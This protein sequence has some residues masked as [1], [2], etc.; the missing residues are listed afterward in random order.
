MRNI[1]KQIKISYATFSAASKDGRFKP[2]NK[3]EAHYLYQSTHPPQVHS[4]E[5]KKKISEARKK[6]LKENPDKVPYLLNH[7]SHGISYP[8][9]YFKDCLKDTK[10]QHKYRYSTY[11]LDFADSENKVD[12][13][14]DGDQHTL[15][16][17]IVEH[18]IKRNQFLLDNGW[19]VIRLLWSKFQRLD[20]AEKEWI[21]SCIIGNKNPEANCVLWIDK[22]SVSHSP[23]EK[24]LAEKCKICECGAKIGSKVKRCRSCYEIASRKVER[25]SKEQLEKDVNEMP[26]VAVGRKYGVTANTIRKWIRYYDR[27]DT[28]VAQ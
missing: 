18:D 3:S 14:I 6:F 4:D 23:Y 25:P 1:K 16:K 2:R 15:D 10:F 27:Q 22:I 12:L 17:R 5:T 26:M 21:I 8:E 19:L 13:E 11:E 20:R 28:L 7:N 9:H 24:R